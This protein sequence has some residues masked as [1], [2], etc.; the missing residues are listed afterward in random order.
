[1]W[2]L[3][4]PN[5]GLVVGFLVNFKLR[6]QKGFLIKSMPPIFVCPR[7]RS[8]LFE[9]KSN[10]FYFAAILHANSRKR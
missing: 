3:F 7:K 8:Y 9:Y 1:M 2:K 10:S 4:K 5:F 6:A